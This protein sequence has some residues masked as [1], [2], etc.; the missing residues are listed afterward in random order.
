[1]FPGPA[2]PETPP[3]FPRAGIIVPRYRNSAVARN[4]VKRRL[5]EILR[6]VV[7]PHIPPVDIV[8]RAS[9]QA[10]SASFQE[11]RSELERAVRQ[12][13]ARYK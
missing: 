7:L 8:V 12:L 1:M 10:Y 2:S 5:R 3:A 6:Q 11:L 9:P 13:Q 4:R